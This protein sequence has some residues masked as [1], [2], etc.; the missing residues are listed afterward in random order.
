MYFSATELERVMTI[1][2][3][4]GLVNRPDIVMIDASPKASASKADES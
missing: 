3:R 2:R 4:L 1:L